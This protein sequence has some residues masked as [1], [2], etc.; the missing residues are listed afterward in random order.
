MTSAS[1][2]AEARIGHVHLKVADLERV[3]EPFYTTKGTNGTGLGLSICKQIIETHRGNMVLE[4]TPGAGTTVHL[5][6]VCAPG[7]D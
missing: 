2:P 7:A 5:D 1:I 3:F 6:L 4:S